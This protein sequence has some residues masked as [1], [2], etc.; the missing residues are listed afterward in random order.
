MKTRVALKSVEKFCHNLPV[1]RFFALFLL[2]LLPL[3]FAFAAAAPYCAL[4]K[5]AVASHFGHHEHPDTPAPEPVDN[6]DDVKLHECGV[7][8]LSCGQVHPAS[9]LTAALP[10]VVAVVALA[11]TPQPQ[12]L[13]EPTERPPRTS[14]A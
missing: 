14:L 7:C 13:Q 8:H 12:H 3:Q 1:R 10:A 5:V 4:E 9:T 11:D 6:G 2:V